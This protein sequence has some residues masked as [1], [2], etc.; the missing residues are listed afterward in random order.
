ME[1]YRVFFSHLDD[2]DSVYEHIG[3]FSSLE[4]AE[5]AIT[6]YVIK[7]FTLKDVKDMEFDDDII[8]DVD[9]LADWLICEGK[10]ARGEENSMSD[11]MTDE[12]FSSEVPAYTYDWDDDRYQFEVWTEQVQ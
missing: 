6:D 3:T 1:I 4:K 8:T 5:T 10:V 11:I 7:N 9:D 12:E 2:E